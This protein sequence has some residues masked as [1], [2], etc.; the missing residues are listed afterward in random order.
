MRI[1]IPLPHPS[2]SSPLS[3]SFYYYLKYFLSLFKSYI[4]IREEGA[5][6]GT[7]RE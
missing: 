2:F 6:E 4:S 3:L 1:A 5:Y 7:G